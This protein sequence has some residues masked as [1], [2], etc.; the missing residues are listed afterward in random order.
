MATTAMHATHKILAAAAGKDHVSPGE[1]VTAKVDLAGINDVYLI[2]VRSFREMLGTKVWDPRKVYIFLDHNTPASDLKVAEAQK[3]FREFAGEQ[4][5]CLTEINE[6]IGHNLLPERGLAR[7]GSVIVIT[8]SHTPIHGAYGAFAAGLGATDM[9]AVLIEGSTWFRVPDVVNIRLTGKPGPG[10]MAKDAAL[11]ILGR[12]GTDFGTYKVI[13]FSGPVVEDLPMEERMVLTVMATEMGAKSAFIKPD[14][15]TIDDVKGYTSEPFTVYE[16]DPGFRYAAE[17]EFDLSGL[18]PQVA[19]PHSVDN[20]RNVEEAEGIPIDQVFVGS[21]TGGKL[22]DIE[23]VAKTL[24]GKKIAGGTRLVVTMSTRETVQKAIRKGY[25]QILLDA[26]AS[27]TSPGCGACSGLLGGIV[28]ARERCV[29][30]ANRNFPGRMGGSVEAEVYLASPLTAA[31]TA[32]T[33]K[34]TSPERL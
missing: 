7:P 29:S 31:A 33:G 6:G 16:T 14:R 17:Y 26:G 13:E 1:V 12:L 22:Y 32:L 30:T 18:K 8:D 10:I 21:C 34:L 15:T 19:L 2:V 9:A 27:I 23:T 11:S 24:A 20:V 4:G 28:A 25:Y 5:C 3:A